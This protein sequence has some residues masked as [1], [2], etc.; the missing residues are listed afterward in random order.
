MNQPYQPNFVSLDGALPG[1]DFDNMSSEDLDRL[2]NAAHQSKTGRSG[3]L[4][5][6]APPP[7]TRVV[8]LDARIARARAE[9]AQ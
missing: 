2:I 5:P 6:S 7:P 3:R 9:A 4:A 1:S 8:D